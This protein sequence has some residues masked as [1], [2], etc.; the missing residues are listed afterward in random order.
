M[1]VQVK[2]LGGKG[3]AFAE[4]SKTP[5]SPARLIALVL[6]TEEAG[7]DLFLVPTV[8]WNY[9]SALLVSRDYLGKKSKPEWGISISAK[10]RPILE[11]FRFDAVLSRI[12]A[13]AA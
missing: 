2:S 11:R 1:E 7:P 5:I 4:K 12:E 9:P 10:T 3:Y 13:G 8:E 6:F